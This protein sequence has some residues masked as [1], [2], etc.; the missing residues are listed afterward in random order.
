MIRGAESVTTRWRGSS[1][2]RS[3][4]LAVVFLM[5]GFLA[6]GHTAFGAEKGDLL[7]KQKDPPPW[8]SRL[9]HSVRGA[10]TGQALVD[11][12][13]GRY[14]VR[15]FIPKVVG[16]GVLPEDWEGSLVLLFEF[17]SSVPRVGV[18]RGDAFSSGIV[19]PSGSAGAGVSVHEQCG[20]A[21]H[22]RTLR[23]GAARG[24]RGSAGP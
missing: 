17:I 4:A 13:A 16:T 9:Y 2:V 5:V 22:S 12:P 23:A 21:V 15:S 10:E 6:P 24:L 1:A 3:S 7:P 11:M 19:E 18:V 20:P 8:Y 14:D